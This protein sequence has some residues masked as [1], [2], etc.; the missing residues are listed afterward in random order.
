MNDISEQ[1]IKENF[2]KFADFATDADFIGTDRVSSMETLIENLGERIAVCP[3]TAK[4]SVG[5]LV[6]Q[7]LSV[8]SKAYK[9]NKGF[10][11]GV[12]KESITIVSLFRNIGMIGNLS[13][14]LLLPQ[15]D[16]W[17]RKNLNE[18]FVYNKDLPFMRMYDR[19]LWLL[20]Q[21][22][23]HLTEEE[24]IAILCSGGNNEDYNRYGEPKLSFVVSSALRLYAYEQ[25]NL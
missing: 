16:Q 2:E 12:N 20:S 19:S 13:E 5:S 11:L 7:N 25:E 4:S 22:G 17:R 24:S 10:N 1:E 3:A 14:D 15:N 21:F 6:Q 18:Y 23:I 9:M 8:L